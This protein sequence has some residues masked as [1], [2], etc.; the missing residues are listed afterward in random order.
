MRRTSSERPRSSR[1]RRSSSQDV[2]RR[3]FALP[4]LT[5][6]GRG[7]VLLQ[8]AT[9]LSARPRRCDSTSSTPRPLSGSLHVPALELPDNTLL[10]CD[11]PSVVR[12]RRVLVSHTGRR[13]SPSSPTTGRGVRRLYPLGGLISRVHSVLDRVGIS[14]P[15]GWGPVMLVV[16]LWLS[17]GPRHGGPAHARPHAR[18]A[19]HAPP[20]MARRWASRLVCSLS[21]E[22]T[23]EKCSSTARKKPSATMNRA[24]AGGDAER[25]GDSGEQSGPGREDEERQ[26][27]SRA[28]ALSSAPAGG[29]GARARARAEG[30]RGDDQRDEGDAGHC[31]LRQLVRDA[32]APACR[33]R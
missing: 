13:S 21:L 12:A 28:R 9:Y 19:R 27:R 7:R 2:P 25:V 24:S 15:A 10:P 14:L 31:S 1:S 23:S 17:G 29:G 11:V 3:S 20:S 6:D 5:D 32:A 18:G 22:R 8:I 16:G 26:A 33:P 4:R 30:R